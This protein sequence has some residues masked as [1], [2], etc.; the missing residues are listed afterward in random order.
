M[1]R[2]QIRM[3]AKATVRRTVTVRQTTRTFVRP[4]AQT[5]A[6][7]PAALPK[8]PS[9]T[10]RRVRV[11]HLRD[12]GYAPLPADDRDY[13]L[14]VCHASEN[15]DWVGPLVAQL[16]AL[17]VGVWY[18]ETAMTVGDS[19]RRSIDTGLARSRFGVVVLSQEF[20]A[21]PWANYEL[22]GLLAREM[23][24]KKVILP[25]WHPNL[26][27]DQVEG[28]SWSL[29]QKLALRG[30]ELPVAQIAA[31]LAALVQTP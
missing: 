3:T 12:A 21:K 23:R 27:L 1:P 17:N 9:L 16:E 22:D 6:R 13:D 5:P 29:S 7:P 4:I 2:R 30:S 26:T 31:E 20:F 24:G 8:Q 19:L 15:K 11:E 14:F 25:V 28:Y 18:D 10:T